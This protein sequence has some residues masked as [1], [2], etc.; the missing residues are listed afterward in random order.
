M[1]NLTVLK[2]SFVLRSTTCNIPCAVPRTM[3]FPA[4]VISMGGSTLV[5]SSILGSTPRINSGSMK[6]FDDPESIKSWKP[7]AF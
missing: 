2:A 4:I 3:L 6:C 5:Y 7:A 1:V